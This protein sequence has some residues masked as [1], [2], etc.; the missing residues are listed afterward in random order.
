MTNE[1]IL[2]QQVEALEKLLQLKQ[3]VIDELESKISKMEMEK[4]NYP[5]Q[6]PCSTV[7]WTH[8]WRWSWWFRHHNH[9]RWRSWHHNIGH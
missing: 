2:A 7:H 8:W 3:A 4:L 9:S 5:Y 1:E 6:P